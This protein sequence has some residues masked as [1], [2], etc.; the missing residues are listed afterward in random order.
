MQS[1][2]GQEGSAVAP[3]VLGDT[4]RMPWSTESGPEETVVRPALAILFRL[5]LG[6]AADN[7]APRFLCYERRG[8]ARVG[9]HWPALLLGSAWAFY[10]KLWLTGTFFACLPLIGVAVFASVAPV[11]GVSTLRWVTAAVAAIWLVPA[12]VAALLANRQLYRHVKRRVQ[13][14]EAGCRRVDEAA[15]LIS[16]HRPTSFAA[17]LVFGGAALALGALAI[18]P[19]ISTLYHEQIVRVSIAGTLA[20]IRPLQI[21]IEDAW[22]SGIS[23]SRPLGYAAKAA[24]AGTPPGGLTVSPVNGRVRLDLGPQ[25]PELRGKAILLAPAVDP[26]QQVQ[27][28][29][30]PVDVPRKYLPQD[31]ARG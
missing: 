30:V 31:C 27:W 29:C 1:P 23:L 2:I 21:A 13:W 3:L 15:T 22:R 19:R 16:A 20:A 26:Q 7:Y 11:V 4:I 10:R 9:W 12:I 24:A 18:A 14:A 5:A 28:I 17:A 6:P 8:G 25:S